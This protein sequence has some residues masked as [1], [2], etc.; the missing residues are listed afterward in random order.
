MN[1]ITGIISEEWETV[2][3]KQMLETGKEEARCAIEAGDFEDGIPFIT[4]IIDGGWAKRSYGHGFSSLSG[5]AVIIGKK[6]GKLLYLGVRNKFCSVCCSNKTKQ[7]NCK[8]IHVCYKN[9]TGSST[10]MEQNGDSSV[11]ARIIER[12]NYGRSLIKLECANH[13]TRC[14]T[15]NLHKISLKT[16]H[17]IDSRRILRTHIP[18]LST[19]VR[20]AIINNSK[21]TKDVE[22]LREDLRN[23]PYHVFGDH[24]N[25]RLEYCKRKN[26]DEIN[27]V[28]LLKQT[29]MFSEVWS[30]LDYLVCKSNRLVTNATTNYA[31]RYMSLVSKFSGGKR[32]NFYK[33]VKTKKSISFVAFCQRREKQNAL[34]KKQTKDRLRK[35]H[36]GTSEDQEYGPNTAKPDMDEEN[37]ETEKNRILKTVQR[38]AMER[39]AIEIKTRGQHENLEWRSQHLI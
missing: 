16:T 22:Q 9:Y 12:V 32:I 4:V 17:D 3:Q 29:K 38:D 37:L 11:Y 34:R 24:S 25:C 27:S 20:S 30:A 23:S 10:G 6:T 21:T 5:V 19:A 7:T 18:R 2:L 13:V 35:K 15:S 39:Y 26:E 1:L 31:E 33:R 28:T 36:Q 14:Y 8:D